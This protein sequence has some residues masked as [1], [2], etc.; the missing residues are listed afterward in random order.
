MVDL[1]TTIGFVADSF[2]GPPATLIKRNVEPF[3]L[4]ISSLKNGRFDLSKSAHLTS[5]K[6]IFI[7]GQSE[8]RHKW[9]IC[10]FRM[11]LDGAK[12]PSSPI[13]SK[14]VWAVA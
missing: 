5:V 12:P 9:A 11:K 6:K 13:R 3:F 1:M 7:N 10:C 14:H 8:S 2:D 4:S